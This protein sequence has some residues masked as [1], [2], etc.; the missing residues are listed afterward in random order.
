MRKVK[1]WKKKL[2]SVSG[3]LKWKCRNCGQIGH[4]SFQ[5]NNCSNHKGGN[6]GNGTGENFCL[7]CRKLGHDK[8]SCFKLKKREA[9]NCHASNFNGNAERQNYESQDVVF[10]ATSHNEILKDDIWICDSGACGHYCNSDKWLF[11]W[12]HVLYVER[13][14]A[15]YG[16]HLF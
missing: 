3:Q 12:E 8:K 2:Y 10:K 11:G 7:Y 14:I 4:K 1:L 16:C 9:R 6:D 13:T 15:N 5:C